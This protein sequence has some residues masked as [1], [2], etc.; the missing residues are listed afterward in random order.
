MIKRQP[1]TGGPGDTRRPCESCGA[2]Q[3]PLNVQRF[4]GR[5]PRVGNV[6]RIGG[7]FGL[8]LGAI[9]VWGDRDDDALSPEARESHDAT[10]RELE[11]IAGGPWPFVEEFRA[12][13]TVSAGTIDA[14]PDPPRRHV[15]SILEA[16][17]L[18]TGDEG[19][20]TATGGGRVL[21]GPGILLVLSGSLVGAGIVL[22]GSRA[23][24]RCP[25]CEI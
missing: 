17:A 24:W 4:G 1:R 12:S 2:A 7:V 16:H 25:R 5:W 3:Q 22:A 20:G 14:T 10:L 13:G 18:A 19:M 8:V 6:L 23:E 11:G 21:G 15:E 9:L